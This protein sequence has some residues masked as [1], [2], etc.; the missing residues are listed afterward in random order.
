[1]LGI[2]TQ[3]PKYADEYAALWL[4]REGVEQARLV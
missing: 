1:M 4:L 2:T 3:T